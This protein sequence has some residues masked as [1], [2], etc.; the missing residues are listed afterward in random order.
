MRY[1]IGLEKEYSKNDILQSYLN[2]AL[3]GGRVYGVQSAARVLLRRG[4]ERREPAAG[5]D[6]HRHP[7]QPR[8]SPNRQAGQQGE[9]R[10]ERLQRDAR[11]P[12]LRARPD[13]RQRQDHQG[14]A[15]R[16]PGHQGRAEGLAHS[17]RVHDGPAVQRRVLL[18]LRRAR[19]R[20][21]SDLRQD[22]GRPEELPHAG[23][24][25]D[26]HHAQ[27]RPADAGA[28][29]CELLHPAGRSPA[30]RGIVERLGRGG[31]RARG[32]HGPEPALR[33]HR[34][35]RTRDHGGELQHGLR[36]RR[37]GRIPDRVRVQG[38]RPAWS[39]C[40]RGTP[41]TRRSTALST[42]SRRRCST[43]ATPATTSAA[44]PGPWR[45]TRASR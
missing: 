9:R 12:Q 2:I 15:R 28:G 5:G 38:V 1:A 43:R 40:R 21:G 11:P 20:A 32:D 4:R 37:L 7:Q 24:T 23:R 41:S 34:Q 36:L 22:R 18:R 42:S 14:R 3:F 45:T 39:G 17:E 10:G 26:L 6:A 13:A 19:H 33:Q 29:R 8:Q 44:L 25:Q 30:R 27:P 16:R 35:P 31:N